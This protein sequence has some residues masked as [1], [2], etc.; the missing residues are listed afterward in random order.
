MQAKI[1]RVSP[2]LWFDDQAELYTKES[3]KASV[4]AVGCPCCRVGYSR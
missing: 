3:A 1:Q 4:S 2:C